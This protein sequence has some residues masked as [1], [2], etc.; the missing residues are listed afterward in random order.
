MLVTLRNVN[1]EVTLGMSICAHT[2]AGYWIHALHND[3]KPYGTTFLGNGG[4]GGQ[5]G[6]P[7]AAYLFAQQ[8][9]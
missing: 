5:R 2:R 6:W 3:V 4:Q 7:Y 8:G 9:P 1:F